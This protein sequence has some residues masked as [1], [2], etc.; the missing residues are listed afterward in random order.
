MRKALIYLIY[1]LPVLLVAKYPVL[2]GIGSTVSGGL[3]KTGIAS[4]YGDKAPALENVAGKVIQ[5][6]IELTGIIFIV[7]TVYAGV[8]YLTAFGDET[9]VKKAK[10]MLVQGV[11]GI[12]IIVSAYAISTFVLSQLGGAVA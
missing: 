11:V 1:I 8:M 7:I 4:G 12:V 6:I 5:T 9:K 3:K 10:T 2:A